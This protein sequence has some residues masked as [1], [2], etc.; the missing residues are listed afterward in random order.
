MKK[1]ITI[2]SVLYVAC[3]MLYQIA[4]D[5]IASAYDLSVNSNIGIANTSGIVTLVVYTL[6]QSFKLVSLFFIK[7][8]YGLVVSISFF[9]SA[10]WAN[11]IGIYISTLLV[12]ISLIVAVV[13][14][15]VGLLRRNFAHNPLVLIVVL[16]FLIGTFNLLSFLLAPNEI[17]ETHQEYINPNGTYEIV[18]R[19][20]YDLHN[21]PANEYY[22]LQEHKYINLGL[23]YFDSRCIYEFQPESKYLGNGAERAKIEWIDNDTFV[24]D[25]VQ[26]EL[27]DYVE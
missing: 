2:I 23:N 5:I 10:F 17:F 15:L 26:Y 24:I 21:T 14:F 27:T 18:R 16:M 25:G 8:R 6:S 7:K 9:F 11:I 19:T 1:K 12:A 3:V 20:T 4:L 13:K 22:K